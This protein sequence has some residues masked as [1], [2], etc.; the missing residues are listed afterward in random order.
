MRP[1]PLHQSR[2]A[3]ELRRRGEADEP[4]DD[5]NKLTLVIST[6][7]PLNSEVRLQ[8]NPV[9]KGPRLAQPTKRALSS[10][11]PGPRRRD[12]APGS[13]Y[14]RPTSG[15]GSDRERTK[16]VTSTRCIPGADYR[17]RD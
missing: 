5:S 8:R 16:T 6:T 17:S 2:D 12:S 3:G 9:R 13:P 14:P 1:L 4:V 15:W 10:P 11:P 7:Q